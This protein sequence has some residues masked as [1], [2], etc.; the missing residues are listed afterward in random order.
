[1]EKQIGLQSAKDILEE[2]T[3]LISFAMVKGPHATPEGPAVSARV[4]WL[5]LLTSAV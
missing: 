4:K 5:I 3:G 2:E 1:M